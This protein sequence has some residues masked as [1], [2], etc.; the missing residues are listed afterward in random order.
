MWLGRGRAHAASWGLAAGRPRQTTPPNPPN[1]PTPSHPASADPP[2]PSPAPLPSPLPGRW[3]SAYGDLDFDRRK[4]PNARAMVAQLHAMGFQVTCWVM[5]FVEERSQAYRCVCGGGWVVGGGGGGMHLG[6]R[7]TGAGPVA[8][9]PARILAAPRATL[10]ACCVAWGGSHPLAPGWR[11]SA[12]P[13][14][15]SYPPSRALRARCREGAARGFFVRSEAG[16]SWWNRR[17]PEL[18]DW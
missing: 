6:G 7:T 16:G 11:A 13:C 17:K 4:F 18:F 12:A 1:P 14:P 2:G 9:D 8:R 10:Q 3:Q 15:A 5:P